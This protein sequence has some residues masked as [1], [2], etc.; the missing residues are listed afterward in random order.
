MKSFLNSENMDTENRVLIIGLDG[1]TFDVIHPLINE[2]RLPNIA[3]L[4]KNGTW[5]NLKSTIP[6]IS[7][8]AWPSFMTGM[9]PGK[10]S[11]FS[12]NERDK[13]SYDLK[14]VSL[15][16]GPIPFWSLLNNKIV[17]MDVP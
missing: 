15:N 2:G 16:K 6:P 10:H 13:N 7:L 5:G 4:M 1:A 12:F 11:I 8:P 17:I 9:N 14:L 3:R